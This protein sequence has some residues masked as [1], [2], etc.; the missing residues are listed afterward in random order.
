MVENRSMPL[1]APPKHLHRIAV[2]LGSLLILLTVACGPV[3]SVADTVAPRSVVAVDPQ[4]PNAG[5]VPAPVAAVQQAPEIPPGKI[6]YVRDGNLWL[7]QGGNSRQFS[8]GGTWFQPSFSP[9]GKEVAYVYWTNNFS[10]VFVMAADGSSTRRLTRGQSASLPDNSWAFRP[11]WSPDGSR[12]AYASDASSWFPQ[13]WLMAKD[14]SGRRQVALSTFEQ[15]S[16][17]DTLSW[18][19]SGTRLAVTGAPT[20][21]DIS[22][23][24]LVDLTKSTSEKLTS[25]ANGAIDPAFSP[26][27][28]AIAYIGRAASQGELWIRSVDGKQTARTDKLPYVRAPAWSPDGKS[29]AVLAPQNGAFEIFI[30]SVRSTATGF[31]LGDPRALTRDGAVDPTSGLTWAP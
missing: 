18:D 24:Y 20:M 28:L 16:W 17:V 10:D 30:M 13:L 9:D 23:I 11:V 7:W 12:L 14:G 29:L 19:P 4:P 31:E 2:V 22:Q 27:G 3:G 6:L 5:T 26:D 1:S 8:E 15:D 21:R 25:H